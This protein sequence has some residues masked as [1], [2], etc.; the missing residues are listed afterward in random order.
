MFSAREKL[1]PVEAR[2]WVVTASFRCL[3][4]RDVDGVWRYAK[5]SRQ[6]E[7]VSGWYPFLN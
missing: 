5:D 1:P 6:I 2:V 7:N 3:G 4:Y